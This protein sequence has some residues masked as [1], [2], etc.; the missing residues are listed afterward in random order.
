MADAP[1]VAYSELPQGVY[2]DPNSMKEVTQTH[3]VKAEEQLRG[4]STILSLR[5]RNFWVLVAI[6]LVAVGAAVGGSVGGA[7]AVRHAG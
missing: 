7:L 5:T 2:H 6:L 3:V 4:P 1:Q